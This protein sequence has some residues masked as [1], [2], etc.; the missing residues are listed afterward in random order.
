M[1]RQR[2]GSTCP[3]RLRSPAESI[4]AA[5]GAPRR[6]PASHVPMS[7]GSGRDP[8]YAAALED[9]SP[10]CDGRAVFA[11]RADDWNARQ[12]ASSRHSTRPGSRTEIDPTAIGLRQWCD[13]D[14]RR[15]HDVAL[16]PSAG[17]PASQAAGR[18]LVAGRAGRRPGAH[19]DRRRRRDHAQRSGRGDG[20]LLPR[21]RARGVVAVRAALGADR[22]RRVGGRLQLLL[23][24]AGPH[25][26][27]QR[28][29]RL[30]RAGGVRDH[31]GRDQR[32]GRAGPPGARG[33][34]APCCRGS[35]GRGLRDADRD[36]RERRRR[37]AR[38][39]GA[40]RHCAGCRQ[41]DGSCAMP[42]ERWEACR[43]S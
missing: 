24:A 36:G 35:T 4:R 19:L 7:S 23:P 33:G 38:A 12:W 27:D 6:A 18:S 29:Q 22:E 34:G 10:V 31:G 40:G 2:R 15:G 9:A 13:D 32:A 3:C 14:N 26:V 8:P 39:G 28:L 42:R 5:A 20:R 16:G 37:A 1:L 17:Q 43:W 30:A 25:A 11:D 21:R 41:A